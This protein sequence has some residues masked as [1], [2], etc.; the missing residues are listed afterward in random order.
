VECWKLQELDEWKKKHN[1]FKHLLLAPFRLH[2][3]KNQDQKS[4][5][6]VPMYVYIMFDNRR[7]HILELLAVIPNIS[8]FWRLEGGEGL[9]RGCGVSEV[10]RSAGVHFLNILLPRSLLGNT[11]LLSILQKKFLCRFNAGK[12]NSFVQCGQL[13]PS[14][15]TMVSQQCCRKTKYSYSAGGLRQI[16]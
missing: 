9:K 5:A 8:E 1:P 16:F 11:A 4:H 15:Y 7:I 2:T 3:R 12:R 6:S 13:T 10:K 14:F